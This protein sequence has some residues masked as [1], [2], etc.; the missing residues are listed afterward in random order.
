[1]L[2]TTGVV[3]CCYFVV[4][5]GC[6]QDGTTALHCAARGGHTCAV[7]AL[8]AAGADMAA[9]DNVSYCCEIYVVA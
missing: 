5:G 9:A 4:F 7:K 2:S 8:V 1:M 3:A 6:V